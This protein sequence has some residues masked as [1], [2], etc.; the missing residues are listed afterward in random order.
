ME[1]LS[2][3]V[4]ALA[5]PAVVFAGISKG[6]FGSGV[7]FASASILALVLEPVV[8][9]ALMLPLLML[10]D[11]ASL[12]AFWRKWDWRAARVLIW[13][14]LPGTLMGAIFFAW[15]DPDALRL[16]I[17]V[18]ALSFVAWQAA[19]HFRLI[20]LAGTRFGARTGFFA[21]VLLGFTSF[22]SHAGGPVAAVYL[23]GQGLSK[24][25]FQATTVL[26]FWAVNV[27]KMALYAG[28]GIFSAE[29]LTLGTA[30][31]PFALLGTWLGVKAHHL[32]SD[33]VFFGVTYV[34][35]TL[36]GTKLIWDAVT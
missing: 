36:T 15:A 31:V 3:P 30:L 7:A 22:V 21:G 18:V 9:I 19:Q 28:M 1:L 13:G 27:F 17:G 8:A 35:L 25:V 26:T 11:C 16:L 6:G 14:G 20:T 29:S 33:R 32:V 12:P 24:T 5:A 10:I 2:W 34:A 23:L 4:F